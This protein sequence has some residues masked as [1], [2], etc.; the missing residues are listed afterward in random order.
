MNLNIINSWLNNELF[1]FSNSVPPD[2]LDAESSKDIT[3]NE[4]QNASLFCVAS[5]NPQPRKFTLSIVASEA[6]RLKVHFVST[7]GITWRRDD[8]SPIIMKLN[9][10]TRKSDTF[11]GELM[12]FVNVDRRYLGAYLCIAKNDVPPAV[13]KRV[14]L[15]INCKTSA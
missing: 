12:S 1:P 3:V 5:G 8:G 13:S 7:T 15:N 9:N 4:G 2:I 14:F 11:E 6:S 10:K